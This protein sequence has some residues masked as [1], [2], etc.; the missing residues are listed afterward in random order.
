MHLSDQETEI[1]VEILS[2]RSQN[3]YVHGKERQV[4]H[5]LLFPIFG[6]Y[7]KTVI[8]PTFEFWSYGVLILV[9]IIFDISIE[10]IIQ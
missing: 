10:P 7:H 6:Q 4:N 5:N 9:D 3:E 1:Y 2:D 8:Q